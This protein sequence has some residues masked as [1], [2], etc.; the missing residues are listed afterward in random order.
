MV[1][2]KDLGMT[3]SKRFVLEKQLTVHASK[4]WIV[5]V[6]TADDKQYVETYPTAFI[7]QE[8]Q[9]LATKIIELLNEGK[10]FVQ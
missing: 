9:D 2:I 8:G 4:C 6:Y 10:E 3:A 5:A 1:R 7:G